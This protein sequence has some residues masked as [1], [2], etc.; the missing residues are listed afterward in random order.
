M[1]IY[2]RSDGELV[3][4]Y[5]VGRSTKLFEMKQFAFH[6]FPCAGHKAGKTRY[7]FLLE[8]YL[9]AGC[10]YRPLTQVDLKLIR[11]KVH[12]R[13]WSMQKFM[14]KGK[15]IETLQNVFRR[16]FQSS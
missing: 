11:T 4:D 5:P 2:S 8:T 12:F 13:A 10:T 7:S 6:C 14:R 15:E 9:A 3:A 16:N 1:L